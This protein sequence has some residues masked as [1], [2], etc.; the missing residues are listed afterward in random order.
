MP[1]PLPQKTWHRLKVLLLCQFV[2]SFY[3]ALSLTTVRAIIYPQNKQ[4][5]ANRTISESNT[6]EFNLMWQ[7]DATVTHHGAVATGDFNGDGLLDIASNDN[8]TSKLIVYLNQGNRVFS[9]TQQVTSAP[10]VL[11]MEG[12]DIDGDGDLDIAT[13]NGAVTKILIHI[14][15]GHGNFTHQYAGDIEVIGNHDRYPV[16]GDANGDGDLDILSTF[17]KQLKIYLN[18]GT[19]IFTENT[20]TQFASYSD[21]EGVTWG[22]INQDGRIDIL[23]SSIS[24][25]VYLNQGNL[26]FSE[27]DGGDFVTESIP[28]NDLILRDIDLDGDLDLALGYS[29]NDLIVSNQIYENDGQG[30]F[31]NITAG[32]LANDANRRT[33]NLDL[34][35][36]D[37][38]GDLDLAT[39]NFGNPYTFKAESSQI[40]RN[41]GG[42]VFTDITA[43]DLFDTYGHAENDSVTFVL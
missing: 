26:L 24:N 36:I 34:G 1:P 28:S 23:F 11:N 2:L 21:I 5:I 43:G 7:S 37:G 27:I 41:D 40:Y 13:R 38:D 18:N 35:D 16:F 4:L 10:M 15:D 19:G 42:G 8:N 32:D 6:T 29:N 30:F 14:N 39:A 17:D 33:Y 31:T 9:L 3:L 20:P 22:D 12:V 25:K